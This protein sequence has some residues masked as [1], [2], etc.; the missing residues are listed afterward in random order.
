MVSREASGVWEALLSGSEGA[1]E[2]PGCGSCSADSQAVQVHS[3]R[4]AERP[5]LA[6]RPPGTT[7]AGLVANGAKVDFDDWHALVH[8]TLPYEEYLRVGVGSLPGGYSTKRI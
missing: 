1:E 4:C 6:R 8:G 3:P 7:L 2:R 5:L